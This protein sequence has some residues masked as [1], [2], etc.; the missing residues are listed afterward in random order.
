MK[1]RTVIQSPDLHPKV[2]YGDQIV[3][4]GSCFAAE[5]AT[6]LNDRKM[7]VY[8]NPVG[9]L[10]NPMS[11]LQ[12][13]EM[14]DDHGEIIEQ[15]L[16]QQGGIWHSFL[17]HGQFSHHDILVVKERIKKA[18]KA[19]LNGLS[20]AKWLVLTFGTAF[21][22][23]HL[24]KDMIVGNCHKIPSK[25]FIR[26]RQPVKQCVMAIEKTI[27]IA[28]SI[29]PNL[30]VLCTVSPIRHQRDGMIENQ[31]SKATL[32]L[33]VDD[34]CR[35]LE[36]VHY[37][38]AYEI[39]MDDLRDYRFYAKDLIHPNE[40]GI[41]YIWQLFS[42]AIIDDESREWMTR[43]EKLNLARQHRQIHTQIPEV[44]SFAKS[45]LDKISC[46]SNALPMISFEEDE[47]YFRSLLR[48]I[49]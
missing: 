36:N 23:R 46:L 41:D 17:H 39:M 7:L 43:I 37:F 8:N 6:R 9:I 44:H 27:Q 1:F 32:L 19:I 30:A 21:T 29:N 22:Y 2:Q 48:T 12:V 15:S 3:L 40:V 18:H 33:A 4:L 14:L 25:L 42:D 49:E 16:I 5:M 13:F 11:I 20:N 28:R 31:R 35:H 26:E 34:L 38:P 47:V 45:Q 10:Y 24:E